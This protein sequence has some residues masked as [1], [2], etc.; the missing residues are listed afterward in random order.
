MEYTDED[1]KWESEEN[2]QPITYVWKY[3]IKD[4]QLTITS[5]SGKDSYSE[6]YTRK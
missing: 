1:G 3:E 2:P 4:N 6:V 5:G